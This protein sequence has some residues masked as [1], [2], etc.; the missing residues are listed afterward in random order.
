MA[1]FNA[2]PAV[3]GYIV[4]TRSRPASTTTPP[5][6][7][8]DPD[9]DADGLHPV[10]LGRLALGLDGPPPCTPP[11]IQAL[12][13][14]YEVPI[15]GRTSSSSDGAPPWAGPWP[16]SCPSSGPGPTRP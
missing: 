5:L 4:Q 15:E 6:A 14:R 12:L 16:C 7:A 1:E 9:K 13:A 3:D 10:N 11:G 2:D 8:L